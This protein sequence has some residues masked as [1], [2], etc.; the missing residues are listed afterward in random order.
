MT[1]WRKQTKKNNN[2]VF[3]VVI[4]VAMLAIFALVLK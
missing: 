1:H 4:T 3:A 2:G